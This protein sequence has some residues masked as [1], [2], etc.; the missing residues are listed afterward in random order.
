MYSSG[1]KPFR[2]LVYV[3]WVI[4]SLP[5]FFSTKISCSV[6]FW[7]AQRTTSPTPPST[8]GRL[9]G[10]WHHFACLWERLP[11]LGWEGGQVRGGKEPRILAPSFLVFFLSHRLLAVEWGFGRECFPFENVRD[12]WEDIPSQRNTGMNEEEEMSGDRGH[13]SHCPAKNS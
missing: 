13:L 7:R 6:Y 5:V 12:H 11:H 8:C 9:L 2:A 4:G 1:R 10:V 3:Y